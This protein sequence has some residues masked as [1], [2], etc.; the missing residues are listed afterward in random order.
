MSQTEKIDILDRTKIMS[1]IEQI[2]VLLS[3]QKQGRVFALDGKWGYGKTYILEQL[4]KKL[5]GLQKEGTNDDRF[6]VFHYNCWQYDYYEE[7]AVAIVS[8]MLEKYGEANKA[9]K[10]LQK[11]Y[12]DLKTVLG[13]I[14]G[15][16]TKNKI[17]INL[18]ELCNEL[19]ENKGDKI[20][21]PSDFDN[22]FAFKKTLDFT[23]NQIRE[24]SKNKTVL[25][26]VDELDRCMPEYAIKVLERLHHMF[27]GLDNVIVLLAIDSTQLEH[28]V[29]EI[30]GEQVDTERYLR[31]FIS[32]RVRL[33]TGKVQNQI[34][35]NYGYYFSRFENLE[36][37]CPIILMLIQLAHID[38]RNMDKLIEK[39]AMIHDLSVDKSIKQPG[40]VLLFEF[41]WGLTKYKIY[42]KMESDLNL[43]KYLSLYWLVEI[44][45]RTYVDLDFACGEELMAYLKELKQNASASV[46]EN[47]DEVCTMH[48][49][50]KGKLWYLLEKIL[51]QK[52]TIQLCDKTGIHIA[53]GV[54]RGEMLACKKFN[55]LG[56]IL[57]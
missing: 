57:I 28:S 50:V 32:F 15:E 23:R 1:D 33:D 17:G 27:E 42:E 10:A 51:T 29:K 30:Y 4:E 37:C 19:E 34:L 55:E 49:D 47:R 43:S 5:V 40:E 36:E 9:E 53:G 54:D 24:L 3:E 41:I 6:Y 44:D 2:L 52:N 8:A 48:S 39:I 13:K 25:L 45:Y 14:A 22:M 16:F 20:G 11:E 56:N 26:V 12:T 46:S 31:K 7:P 38:I 21:N 18:V 35:N